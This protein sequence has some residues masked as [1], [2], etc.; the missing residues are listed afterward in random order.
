MQNA[1]AGRWLPAVSEGLRR[2]KARRCQEQV[3]GFSTAKGSP[4]P[5]TLGLSISNLQSN[6]PTANDAM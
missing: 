3:R 6:F 5:G 4:P 1:A 2:I